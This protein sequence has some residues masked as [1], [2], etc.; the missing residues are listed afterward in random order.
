MLVI[1]L[2]GVGSTGKS[3]QPIAEALRDSHPD[4]IFEYPDGPEPFDRASGRQ[5]FSVSG[6]TTLNRPLRVAAARPS[7][8]AIVSSLIAKHG[9]EGK[10]EQVCFLGFSQ[11]TIMALDA[12]ATGRWK[13]GMLVG[14]AGRLA[15][16]DPI[17]PSE[18][19][20]FLMHGTSDTVIPYA[21][22]TLA[23]SALRTKGIEAQELLI[24][25]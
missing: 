13:I 2:H 4:A 14:F 15:L 18:T 16:S 23:V 12:I 1:L 25:G 5:W 17:L 6:V 11:G 21:E 19:R 3:M 9:F 10:L 7:F 22:T 20:V 8:D 24:P